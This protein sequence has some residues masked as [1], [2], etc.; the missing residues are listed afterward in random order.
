MLDDSVVAIA[1]IPLARAPFRV[2]LAPIVLAV[3]GVG[4]GVGGWLVP[5]GEIVRWVALIA[6]AT[7]VVLF[8]HARRRLKLVA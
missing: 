1:R 7:G 6:L 4:I 3:V 5:A 8:P 2:L